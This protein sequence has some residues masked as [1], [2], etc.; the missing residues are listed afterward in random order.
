MTLASTVIIGSGAI[1]SLL[2]A[3]FE[4]QGYPYSWWLR[5]G[6]RPTQS[7]LQ[8]DGTTLPLQGS[9]HSKA[10]IEDG[11]VILLP[12]KAYQIEQALTELKA[13]LN[14]SH[15]LV[16]LHNGMGGGEL[17]QAICPDIPCLLA[18]TTHG[19]FTR[20][21]QVIHTGEGMTQVG[22]SPWS[23]KLTVNRQQEV[24]HQLNAGLMPCQLNPKIEQAL[25]LKLAINCAINPLTALH[26][27]NN[28]EL[29]QPAYASDI[30][31]VTRE[32][33]AVAKTQGIEFSLDA[34]LA[35]IYLVIEKTAA[36]FSSMHQDVKHQRQTEIDFICGYVV[37]IG[38]KKG[39]AVNRNAFFQQSVKSL[40]Y[41]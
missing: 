4:R 35:Q 41:S 31:Q 7:V 23:A 19:A 5:Q 27:V 32:V 20:G 34:L 36:N 22:L 9:V 3:G 1:A 11:S 18:T 26:K 16:L 13:K 21:H 24:E 10:I 2:A 12:L 38:N 28:G 6:R 25:W 15:T 39:I 17:A 37:D 8:R 40:A 30:T 33:I 14:P 29:A